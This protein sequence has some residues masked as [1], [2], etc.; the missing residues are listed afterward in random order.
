MAKSHGGVNDEPKLRHQRKRPKRFAVG[1]YHTSAMLLII[2][3]VVALAGISSSYLFGI[4]VY[5]NRHPPLFHHISVHVGLFDIKGDITGNGSD[6]LVVPLEYPPILEELRWLIAK[7]S[8]II[9]LLFGVLALSIH[10]FLLCCSRNR[11][12]K[13]WGTVATELFSC[14]ITVIG[15]LVCLSLAESEIEGVHNHGDE[16]LVRMLQANKLLAF[17]AQVDTLANQSGGEQDAPPPRP[18]AEVA[19]FNLVLSEPRRSF[20]VLIAADFVCLLAF[21]AMLVY[22]VR[23]SEREEQ[24]RKQLQ[25]A[26]VTKPASGRSPV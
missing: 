11:E 14:L 24:L 18:S 26:K 7:A 16:T 19:E 1:C 15:L 5:D 3:L 8:A 6:G 23:L 2:G 22:F 13:P 25:K 4:F 10:A 21:L 9:A 20:Y 12:D 17:S